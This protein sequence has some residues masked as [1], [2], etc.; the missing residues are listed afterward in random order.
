MID[1]SSPEDAALRYVLGESDADERREFE[2]RLA[3][4]GE[5]QTLVRELETGLVAL[6][7][8]APRREP[9]VKIWQQIEKT[10]TKKPWWPWAPIVV[11]GWWRNGW[12]ATTLCA[13]GWLT[14]AFLIQHRTASALAAIKT[15]PATI[16]VANP[17]GSAP[18]VR[19]SPPAA[20]TN[21]TLAVL[22]GRRREI[23]ELQ[24]QIAQ[25]QLQ[26]TRL[27]R[28]LDQQSALLG[29][30]NR[31]KFYHL[32]ST[33]ATA[34]SNAALPPLSPG[35]QRAVAT[36][37]AR[38]LGWLPATPS[39]GAATP[40]VETVNGVDF[41]HLRTPQNNSAGQTPVTPPIQSP[42]PISNQVQLQP[43]A[44]SVTADTSSTTIP[45][46]VSG[47]NLVVA[48][49]PTIAPTGSSVTFTVVDANQNQT[50]GTITMGE[51]PTVVII[52]ASYESTLINTSGGYAVTVSSLSPG[53]QINTTTFFTTSP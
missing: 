35:L 13:L 31:I 24:R 5:L 48:V 45:A 53:G 6:A 46:Y 9:P 12:A 25:L 2:S 21:T 10:V 26:T 16:V 4:S 52:P 28:T 1:V 50:G 32:V 29:E 27:S 38:D 51:N 14:Y 3:L 41:V 23:E 15:Q 19:N 42:D 36:A 7:N 44:G 37:L 39:N 34:G 49:D 43:R 11:S 33:S 47:D 18:V 8:A 40:T 20:D 22:Q 30:T 17:V